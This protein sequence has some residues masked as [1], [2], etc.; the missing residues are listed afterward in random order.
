MATVEVHDS[1]LRVALGRW[2]L[3]LEQNTEMMREIGAY[4]LRS[5]RR[6]FRQQGVPADSWAPLAP[7]TIRSNPKIYGP[8]HKLLIRS[9]RLLNSIHSEAQPNQVTIGTNLPYAGVHQ[10]G[11]RDRQ[12]GFGPRTLAQHNA[13]ADVAA[14]SYL[15]RGASLGT[16]KLGN[17]VRRIQGPRN[18]MTVNVRA[19]TRHQNIPAR[20]YLVFRPEDPAAIQ[21]L[22]N[23]Y[24][25]RAAKAAGLEV[26]E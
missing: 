8:G 7:S 24:C 22:V 15:R 10:F 2:K 1:E 23:A 9:G 11:S 6:T 13:T 3:S 14:H 25:L 5:V 17:R 4:M 19:H 26:Q 21:K 20:P 16:G 18:A 12:G